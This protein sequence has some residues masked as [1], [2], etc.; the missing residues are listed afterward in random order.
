[1]EKY[2]KGI[3]YMVQCRRQTGEDVARMKRV[4]E[5][6]TA[7]G[8][9]EEDPDYYPSLCEALTIFEQ[10]SAKKGRAHL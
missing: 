2:T 5:E 10:R 8:V 1:M 9:E 6:V 3:L 7:S 4:H